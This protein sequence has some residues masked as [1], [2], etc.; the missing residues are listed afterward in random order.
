MSI[1]LIIKG[2]LVTIPSSGTGPNWAEGI[3]D[4]ITALTEAVNAITGTYD[5]APQIQNIDANNSSTN[6]TI[7]NLIFPPAEVRSTV[8]YYS[9]Y[10]MTE[11]SGVGDEQEVAEGGTL[12]LVYNA[13]NPITNKWEIAQER[14]G[15]ASISFSVTDLGQVQFS[16]T[17]LTGINHVGTLSFR[18]LSILNS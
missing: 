3:I 1:R 4:A 2:T 18:A 7:S 16:T 10:R 15:N 13:S 14:V 17:A 8:I 12:T 9:V 11:D 6:V 5:V